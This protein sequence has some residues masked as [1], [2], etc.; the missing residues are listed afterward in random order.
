LP[1]RGE[2]M[3]YDGYRFRVESIGRTRILKVRVEKTGPAPEGS[4]T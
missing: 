4:E 1:E 3:D 2:A